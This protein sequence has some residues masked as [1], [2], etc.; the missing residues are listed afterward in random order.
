MSSG[1][2]ATFAKEAEA[3]GGIPELGVRYLFITHPFATIRHSKPQRT[4]RLACLS[5]AA[6]VRSE[7][8]SNPSNCFSE[9]SEDGI[10]Q[11]RLNTF[12]AYAPKV[13]KL[14]IVKFNLS[15]QGVSRRTVHTFAAFLA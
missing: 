6:S 5:H 10:R 7:P 14:H 1:I 11:I 13:L 8:G 15:R 3:S 4:V 9:P 12:L 2:N